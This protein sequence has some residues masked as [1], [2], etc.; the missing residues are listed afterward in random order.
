MTEARERTVTVSV[1]F[2]KEVDWPEELQATASLQ[3]I[4]GTQLTPQ[5]AGMVTGI[6]F[7][8]G[9]K[10]EEGD[11]LVQ[12]N[13]ATQ[14]AQL[15]HDR[16]AVALAKTEL[17]QQR[18]LFRK[19]NTSQLALQ[20]AETAY[21]QAQA[22]VSSDLATIAKL[23]IRAPFT[24]HLGLRQVSLGQYVDT[25]NVVV[26]LQ[27]WNP[28][29]CEFQIPQQQ[30]AQLEIGEKVTLSVP[31][32]EGREFIG[33]LTAIGAEVQSGTRN[34]QVQATLANQ[35][36]SLRPGMYGDVT[37]DTGHAQKVLAVPVSAVSYNTYGEYVYLVEQGKH[38]LIAQQ[39]NVQTGDSRNGL[40][41]IT[42]GLK[43]GQRIVTA[44]QVKLY[45]GAT[46]TIASPPSSSVSKSVLTELTGNTS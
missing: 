20:Q 34:V 37:V 26:D 31:G 10:V 25:T 35:D 44:G 27:Q 8:S 21:I 16:S 2:V 42:R 41:A 32:I 11:L 23:K 17:S 33:K 38:G 36:S 1:D 9:T 46:L 4:Q 6:Y 28:I 14:Q 29:Y 30:I 3:A 19:Y 7:Q 39:E 13:D 15:R 5:L 45:P 18:N 40:T 43:T 12:L 22:A 24:G